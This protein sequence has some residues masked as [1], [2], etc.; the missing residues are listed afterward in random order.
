MISCQAVI[1]D[2]EWGDSFPTSCPSPRCVRNGGIYLILSSSESL[3]NEPGKVNI[4]NKFFDICSSWHTRRNPLY[5]GLKK[6][7]SFISPASRPFESKRHRRFVRTQS[8]K[9]IMLMKILLRIKFCQVA[10][11]RRHIQ[12]QKKAQEWLDLIFAVITFSHRKDLRH[13][14]LFFV[15]QP[16]RIVG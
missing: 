2:A 8:T 15:E 5:S 1:F 16:F 10:C 11:T 13:R 14:V 3:R 6:A 9:M 4:P 12:K 7:S